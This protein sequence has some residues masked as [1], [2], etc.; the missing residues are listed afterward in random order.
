[1][2]KINF[3]KA[4]RLLNSMECR[5]FNL[6]SSMHVH[7][8]PSTKSLI[9][10]SKMALLWLLSLLR[11]KYQFSF[12]F[13]RIPFNKHRVNLRDPGNSFLLN[14]AFKARYPAIQTVFHTI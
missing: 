11:L 4:R 8:K 5:S 2:F 12:L 6:E 10:I 14:R 3:T 9:I 13:A 1:M 7:L